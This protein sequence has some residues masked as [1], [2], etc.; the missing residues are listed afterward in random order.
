[1]KPIRTY[2]LPELATA[3][4]V[5]A[6]TVRYYISEGL[7]PSPGSGPQARY[8]GDH[9]ARIRLIRQLQRDHLPLAEIR[10]RL[11]ELSD[12]Q[13]REL[14]VRTE[15]K[16][17]PSSAL[18]YIR[19]AIAGHRIAE[20]MR[21]HL[22]PPPAAIAPPPDAARAAF[23]A[24][25][26]PIPPQTQQPDRSHWE[27]ISLAPDIELHIRRPLTREHNRVV[28]RLIGLAHELLEEDQP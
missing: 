13:V 14:A 8:G 3:T 28:S 9:V 24:A 1:M 18:D 27:R 7:L 23:A 25:P 26:G 16:P 22:A 17:P 5:T 2:S 12:E 21:M 11:G 6:R 19:S 10:R 4:G 15:K 20:P